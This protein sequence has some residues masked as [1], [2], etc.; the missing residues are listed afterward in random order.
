MTE[1]TLWYFAD[2][3]CSWCWGFSPVVQRL[4]EK[5]LH[6][7]K[8]A[9]VLGGLRPYT[10]ELITDKLREE[11]LHHWREVHKMTG[12]AFSF[13]GA[14]P[15]GFVYD[16]EP[17]SRAVVAVGELS[18]QA[19]FGYFTAVQRAFYLEQKDV[20]QESVLVE[21][22]TPLSE[23]KQQFVQMFHSEHIKQ[24]T[25]AHFHK[26][27]QFG[28]RGFPTLILQDEQQYYLLTSGYRPYQELE[29]EI[30]AYLSASQ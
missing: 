21:L 5:Y 30:D 15:E 11:I 27:R 6:R 23:D 2:P 18:Q 28:V 20:T 7:M 29:S 24:K 4:K 26:S 14:M 10:R 16:T 12:Q 13:A 1:S 3:M 25:Q 9:L 17:A 8:F 19:T 22:L